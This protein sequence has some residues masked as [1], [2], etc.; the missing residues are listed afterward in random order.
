LLGTLA[1]AQN[2]EEKEYLL[3]TAG[4]SQI[5]GMEMLRQG[6]HEVLESLVQILDASVLPPECPAYLVFLELLL[7]EFL[8][9]ELN[10]EYEEGLM[11]PFLL[12]LRC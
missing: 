10:Q 5:V 6:F 1:Y 3:L 9:R 7:V 11:D 8:Q 2:S 4:C 12:R